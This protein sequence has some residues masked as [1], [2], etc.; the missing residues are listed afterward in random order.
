[1]HRNCGSAIT[2]LK[3]DNLKYA[4]LSSVAQVN[5]GKS[6]HLKYNLQELM[7]TKYSLREL[8]LKILTKL[9]VIRKEFCKKFSSVNL[10]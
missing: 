1:M 10:N 9:I 2:C 4:Y 5:L 7:L 3:F 8:M 6:V